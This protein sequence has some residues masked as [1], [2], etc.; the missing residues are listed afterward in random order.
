MITHTL[1]LICK[2]LVWNRN[3]LYFLT[4]INVDALEGVTG[5]MMHK[6]D[7]I[8]SELLGFEPARVSFTATLTILS[9]L[10]GPDRGLRHSQVLFKDILVAFEVLD[11]RLVALRVV[12]IFCDLAVVV[13][14]TPAVIF[15]AEPLRN[16]LGNLRRAYAA[17]LIF[18]DRL[19]IE[20]K[21]EVLPFCIL[22]M[23]AAQNRILSGPETHEVR[24]RSHRELVLLIQLVRILEES[25]CKLDLTQLVHYFVSP[26]ARESL[27]A[28]RLGV[29]GKEFISVA[30]YPLHKDTLEG[31]VWLHL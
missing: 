20:C 2:V 14:S 21:Q 10:E 29:K 31:R 1:V 17:R 23:Q 26:I 6:Y 24:L 8:T 11:D 28:V 4:P 3:L 19:V 25:I 22:R 30:A 9:H 27:E 13:K 5:F 7:P 16:L 15:N 18:E 12:F